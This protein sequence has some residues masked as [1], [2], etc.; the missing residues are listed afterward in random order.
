VAF[1]RSALGIDPKPVGLDPSVAKAFPSAHLTL[2][3]D[4]G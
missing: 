4:P 2:T 3:A 1:L